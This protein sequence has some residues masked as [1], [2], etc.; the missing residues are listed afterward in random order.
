ME[1]QTIFLQ[2]WRPVLINNAMF[3]SHHLQSKMFNWPKKTFHMHWESYILVAN[4]WVPIRSL[5]L[6]W[7]TRS[8]GLLTTKSLMSLWVASAIQQQPFLSQLAILLPS[9][10]LRSAC[11]IMTASSKCHKNVIRSM[12]GM[13]QHSSFYLKLQGTLQSHKGHQSE[14]YVNRVS[15]RL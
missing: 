2:P 11:W 14:I 3:P 9:V 4:Q 10:V 8:L 13:D 15:Q 6:Q 7:H 12:H 5:H 1:L